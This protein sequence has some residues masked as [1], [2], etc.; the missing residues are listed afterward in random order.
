MDD[1][2]IEELTDEELVERIQAGDDKCFAYLMNKYKKVVENKTSSYFLK[3]GEKEDIIQE[4]MIGLFKATRAY[5]RDMDAS[6]YYF[7]NICIDR[8]IVTA[9]K[10]ANR[11]KHSPLNEYVS[12]NKPVFDEEKEGTML[13]YLVSDKLVL[14]PEL[15]FIGKESANSIEISLEKKLS[16]FELLIYNLFKDGLTYTEIAESLEKSPKSIDNAL[17]RIKKKLSEVI[18]E[19][20]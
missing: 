12:L 17:Q 19:H 6:F 2:T 14:D 7:A 15:I 3:W 20:S 9:V 8:Q 4:G 5:N 18:R 10:A 11:K 1:K 16:K 13:E